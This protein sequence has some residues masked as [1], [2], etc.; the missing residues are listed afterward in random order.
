MSNNLISQ[1]S[2]HNAELGQALKD[3]KKGG[4]FGMFSG[5]KSISSIFDTEV[6]RKP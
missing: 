2:G 3:F 4:L 1:I 6:E 5:G